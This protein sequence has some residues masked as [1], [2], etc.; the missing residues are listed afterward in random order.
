MK[1]AK[2]M[3]LVPAGR[4]EPST[5]HLTELDKQM[6]DVLKN[7]QLS[8]YEK[9]VKYNYILSRNKLIDSN[10]KESIKQNDNDQND[11]LREI[12]RDEINKLASKS[13]LKNIKTEPFKTNPN[14]NTSH[15]NIKTELINASPS[16]SD[17]SLYSRNS[18]DDIMNSTMNMSDQSDNVDMDTSQNVQQKHNKK[19][20]NKNTIN[21]L[22]RNSD[23]IELP[24][25]RWNT[26]LNTTQPVAKRLR[27][28]KRKR[29][30]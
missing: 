10:I 24:I 16:Y 18:Q 2:K 19:I 6:A 23:S 21:L 1:F 9:I 8:D 22:R 17:I 29:H 27:S 26:I 7:N 12:I 4:P 11:K 30:M 14:D 13:S 28:S 25:L 15:K 5:Q 20:S 3:I